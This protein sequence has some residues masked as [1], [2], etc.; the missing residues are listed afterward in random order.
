MGLLVVSIALFVYFPVV[1]H[2]ACCL[3]EYKTGRV[4]HEA[5]AVSGAMTPLELIRVF[6]FTHQ[7][8]RTV[9]VSLKN[10]VQYRLRFLDDVAE[11][12]SALRVRQHKRGIKPRALTDARSLW[13]LR[14][15]S[16]AMSHEASREITRRFP[17]VSDFECRLYA[18]RGI[19]FFAK[20]P[21]R[22]QSRL[23]NLAVAHSDVGP[24]GQHR[25]V[26]VYPGGGSSVLS[27]MRSGSGGLSLNRR[28]FSLNEQSLQAEASEDKADHTHG[29]QRPLWSRLWTQ[30]F[31]RVVLA[32]IRLAVGAVCLWVGA[33][34]WFGL[35][36]AYNYRNTV[37]V[38]GCCLFAVGLV[39]LFSF[40]W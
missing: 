18:V 20:H 36:A 1:V 28:G 24:L 37:G 29:Y 39:V 2:S 30:P 7:P 12:N 3:V 16:D 34:L 4:V 32:R 9:W 33:F 14:Q 25:Y 11:V 38:L 13:P 6:D 35:W 15:R 19:A 23:A 10:P 21:D 31:D 40:P 5:A 17:V 22:T 8:K 26:S 27:G